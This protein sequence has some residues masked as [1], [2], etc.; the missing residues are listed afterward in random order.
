MNK[1]EQSQDKAVFHNL[2]GLSVN[3][4][5]QKGE[6][7]SQS[8][9]VASAI[10]P[11]RGQNPSESTDKDSVINEWCEKNLNY[12]FKSHSVFLKSIELKYQIRL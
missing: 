8:P 9:S 11:K 2:I 3:E 10:E 6:N 7:F 5:N 1:T 12:G 4:N